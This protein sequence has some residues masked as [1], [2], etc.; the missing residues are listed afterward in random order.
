MY[1][2]GNMIIRQKL[3][4]SQAY[5]LLRIRY[6]CNINNT[7]DQTNTLHAHTQTHISAHILIHTLFNLVGAKGYPKCE[8]MPWGQASPSCFSYDKSWESWSIHFHLYVDYH[9]PGNLNQCEFIIFKFWVKEV[10]M[11]LAGV[12]TKMLAKLALLKALEKSL[13]PCLFHLL[14]ATAHDSFLPSHHLL[15]VSSQ[16]LLPLL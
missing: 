1:D 6:M 11:G 14:E 12:K 2:L 8:Y 4:F 13:F 10:E 5:H 15:P 7:D 9:W 16:H 3:Y